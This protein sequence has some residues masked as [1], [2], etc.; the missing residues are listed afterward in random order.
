MTDHLSEE[1]KEDIARKR[2]MKRLT[3]EEMLAAFNGVLARAQAGEFDLGDPDQR[4]TAFQEA[5]L[6]LTPTHIEPGSFRATCGARGLSKDLVTTKIPETF[7]I[8][9]VGIGLTYLS[10]KNFCYFKKHAATPEE[11]QA[12]R[13]DVGALL[14]E[15]DRPAVDRLCFRLVERLNKMSA[16]W[17]DRHE[18]RSDLKDLVGTIADH[19]VGEGK[20]TD[21]RKQVE[22]LIERHC[23]EDERESMK[24]HTN[25]VTEE[26]GK[27]H[28]VYV[29]S[30]C[31]ARGGSFD[32]MRPI[33]WRTAD[34]GDFLCPEPTHDNR[35]A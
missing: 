1:E 3:E 15:L 18:L 4:R 25:K 35:A 28:D 7:L 16:E 33:G 32:G 20:G 27:P 23:P 29:C 13:E 34:N 2:G 14:D 5:G 22:A 30:E 8:P 9:D 10:P 6:T 24:E 26:F 11:R 21:V 31:P 12:L 19:F 17:R